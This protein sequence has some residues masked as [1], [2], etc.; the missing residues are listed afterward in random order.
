[1]GAKVDGMRRPEI[2]NIEE[3]LIGKDI[4]VNAIRWPKYKRDKKEYIITRDMLKHL[5]PGA[6][7]LDLAVDEPNPIETCHATS[8][9]NPWY[10]EEGVKHICIYGYPGLAPVSCSRRYSSQIMPLVLDIADNGLGK[11]SDYIKKAMVDLKK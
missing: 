2:K 9:Q 5:N 7:V 3:Y 8:L 10:Y 6:I 11:C 1:M 4:V